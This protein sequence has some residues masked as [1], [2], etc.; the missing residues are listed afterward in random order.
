MSQPKES[1]ITPESAGR[2]LAARGLEEMFRCPKKAEEDESS[3]EGGDED[4]D[5]GREPLEADA[6]SSHESED[7]FCV[8]LPTSTMILFHALMSRDENSQYAPYYRAYNVTA[9]FLLS[10]IVLLQCYREDY[11]NFYPNHCSYH[12]LSP[13]ISSLLLHLFP[14][15]PI[16]YDLFLSFTIFFYL[17]PDPT[18][19]ILIIL[20]LL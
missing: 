5:A 11:S 9:S 16:S 8:P 1:L 19:A 15:L 12:L 20:S 13:P 3:D 17:L 6:G 14:S 10:L 18:I 2:V 7:S 4:G